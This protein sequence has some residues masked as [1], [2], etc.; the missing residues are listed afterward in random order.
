MSDQD[1]NERG[2][3]EEATGVPETSEEHEEAPAT[4][5]GHHEDFRADGAAEEATGVDDQGVA[6]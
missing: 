3:A 4:P 1:G 6:R 5:S 2:A